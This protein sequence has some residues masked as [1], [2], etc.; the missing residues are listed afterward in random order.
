[1]LVLILL[2]SS[3]YNLHAAP[4]KKTS[5]SSTKQAARKTPAYKPYTEVASMADYTRLMSE[6]KRK[7]VILNWSSQDCKYCE[8][9]EKAWC[10]VAKKYGH[11][12]LFCKIDVDKKEFDKLAEKNDIASVPRTQFIVDNKVR[13]LERGGISDSK[14]LGK[15]VEDFFEDLENPAPAPIIPAKKPSVPAKK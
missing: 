7:P 10:V 9:M 13:R 15:A 8:Q 1:M 4:Q 12:A 11:K 6:S 5:A 14:E 2:A 3:A